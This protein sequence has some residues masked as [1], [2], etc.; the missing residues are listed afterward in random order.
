MAPFALSAGEHPRRKRSGRRWHITCRITEIPSIEKCAGNFLTIAIH[1]EEAA[2]GRF[3]RYQSMQEKLPV[4]DF[5][6]IVYTRKNRNN[7]KRKERVI[8]YS[9][10]YHTEMK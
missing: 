4:A 8:V 9:L 3:C 6:F 1:S 10:N 7:T 2:G 5:L